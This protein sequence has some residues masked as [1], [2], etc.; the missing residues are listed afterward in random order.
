MTKEDVMIIKRDTWNP[1]YLD[2]NTLEV[3]HKARGKPT[4]AIDLERCLTSAGV[5]DWIFQMHM[6]L[7]MT[8]R[9]LCSL[10]N[11]LLDVIDP[12]ANLCSFGF[13]KKLSKAALKRLVGQMHAE[14]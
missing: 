5:L 2:T 3:V 8:D 4:Y 14:T 7:W 12:Q 6:K 1:W 10:L 13:G 11:I 9:V